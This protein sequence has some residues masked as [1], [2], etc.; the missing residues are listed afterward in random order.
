MKRT[1]R[2]TE[3][4]N[5]QLISYFPR[6]SGSIRKKDEDY[7]VVI[8]YN[9]ADYIFPMAHRTLHWLRPKDMKRLALLVIE[10]MIMKTQGAN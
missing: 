1:E 3:E 10:H 4:L 7:E 6:S 5:N 8:R 2:F 9:K